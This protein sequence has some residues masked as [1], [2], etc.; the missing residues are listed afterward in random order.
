MDDPQLAAHWLS[1][2][3]DP[4][5]AADLQAVFELVATAIVSHA[6]VCHAS[7]QCCKFDTFGHKLYVTGLE[8][9]YT[10]ARLPDER[11]LSR[12]TLDDAFSHGNCPFQLHKLCTVHEIRP[13][14]CRI[15]FC[16]DNAAAWMND[17]SERVVTQIK[18]IHERHEIEYRYAEWRSLLEMFITD[19]PPR[20]A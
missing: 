10:V 13:A 12:D 16:E 5:V 17:L 8:T 9:A 1:A 2:A 6:P 7:G 3:S 20:S 19:P 4:A 14:A 11:L 15:F 18:A